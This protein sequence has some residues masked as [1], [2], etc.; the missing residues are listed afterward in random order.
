VRSRRDERRA[1][2]V[3]VGA[4]ALN[5]MLAFGRPISVRIA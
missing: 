5:R 4:Y 1:T 3:D 2:E